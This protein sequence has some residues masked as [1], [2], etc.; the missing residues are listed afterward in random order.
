MTDRHAIVVVG[1]PELAAALSRVEGIGEVYG[2]P[3][4]EDFRKGLGEKRYP[5]ALNQ[6]TIIV[7]DNA[8]TEQAL[9]FLLAKL[10]AAK[11]NILMVNLTGKM[12][13]WKAKYPAL[14]ALRGTIAVNR[15][16]GALTQINRRE[17]EPVSW[18]N[19]DVREAQ[20][21]VPSFAHLG[22]DAP[23][24]AAPSPAPSSP[25]PKNPRQAAF[26]RAKQAAAAGGWHTVEGEGAGSGS[27]PAPRQP[28][29]PP[30]P[31]PAGPPAPA[32]AQ[33]PTLPGTPATPDSPAMPASP[34]T[35]PPAAPT[36]PPT[37]PTPTPAPFGQPGGVGQPGGGGQPG[38][39]GGWTRLDEAGWE[40]PA[41][42][43]S[44]AAPPAPPAPR[45]AGRAGLPV[46]DESR[47]ALH[48]PD[49]CTV[50]TVAAPKGG[51]GKS[52][53]SLNT[54]AFL[55]LRTNQQVAII[56]ANL[57][58]A[59]V[60]KYLR[61]VRQKTILDVAKNLTSITPENIRDYM[62][63]SQEGHFFA[64]L[65]PDNPVQADPTLITPGLYNRIL[66]IMRQTFDYIVIDTPVAEYYH[67][68]V[69]DFAVR[70][71][72][73]IV[74]VVT[75]NWTTVINT[76]SYLRAIVDEPTGPRAPVEKIGWVFNQSLEDVDC[77]VEDAKQ[78]LSRFRYLG[79][80]PF[81][82]D[83]LRA[84]NNAELIV[85]SRNEVINAAFARWVGNLVGINFGA[86][87]VTPQRRGGFLARLFGT[88][89]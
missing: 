10:L 73:R 36:A 1:F 38:G 76:A 13:D 54:A 56:D 41:A 49:R 14:P 40:K 45:A 79:E 80:V 35:P 63:Y 39:V 64:L 78:H 74:T 23:A 26:E 32:P 66:S 60:S 16:L 6:V 24:P 70:E 82:E 53:M 50:I 11:A 2:E 83:W 21:D 17:Y 30:A 42:P 61:A 48:S 29:A 4:V 59:D 37:A 8:P 81:T 18:G 72:D 22:A 27:G 84:A 46:I 9:D 12:E 33:E 89:R 52:T 47:V 15:V 58:Q 34:H 5:T 31:A 20:S 71:A 7:A 85:A 86:E 44:P 75:P 62:V 69:R 19:V 77:S 68:I 67:A 55:G 88:G 25:A 51:A 57:Q 43:A 28:S 65:G 87:Q 3:T